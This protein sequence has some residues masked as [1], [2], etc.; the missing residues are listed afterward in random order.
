[1][2]G[3]QEQLYALSGKRYVVANAGSDYELMRS[4]M[5][6]GLLAQAQ[7]SLSAGEPLSP[8]QQAALTQ[9]MVWPE[10]QEVDG[11]RVLVPHVYLAKASVQAAAAANLG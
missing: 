8:A 3:L 11:Q 4:L 1:M 7:L 6:A 10:W 2:L 9:D 5:D